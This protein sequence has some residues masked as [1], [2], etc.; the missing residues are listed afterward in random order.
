MGKHHASPFELTAAEG[1]ICET[2]ATRGRELAERN[3][4]TRGTLKDLEAYFGEVLQSLFAPHLSKTLGALAN[5]FSL[6]LAEDLSHEGPHPTTL[7]PFWR[8]RCA[9]YRQVMEG[10]LLAYEEGAKSL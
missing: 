1:V 10:F 2:F 6:I 9:L 8:E 3:A 5:E 4:S 7:E